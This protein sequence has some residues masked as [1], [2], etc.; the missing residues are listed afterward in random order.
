[1]NRRLLFR[2]SLIL[3]LPALAGLF[4]AAQEPYKIPPQNVLDILNAPPTPRVSMSPNHEIMLL[5]ETETMPS[6]AYIAQPLLRIAGM[7]ITPANSSDQVLNF[8]TGLTL[9]T[10]KEVIGD[11]VGE[12]IVPTFNKKN[13]ERYLQCARRDPGG[14]QAVARS[15][16]QYVPHWPLR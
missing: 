3:L 9:K 12:L 10:I 6:I 11:R 8:S 15:D 4:L 2:M 5:I 16:F 7:R 14:V 13:Q 1:M